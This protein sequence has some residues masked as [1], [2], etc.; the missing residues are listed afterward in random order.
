MLLGLVALA[1]AAAFVLGARRRRPAA[2]FAVG[3]TLV[4]LVP[5][6]SIVWRLDPVAVRPLYVAALGPVLLL[7]LA[8]AHLCAALRVAAPPRARL[9]AATA[10]LLLAATLPLVALARETRQR[11]Q[12]WTD[13]AA[14]WADAALKAPGSSRPWLNLGVA[15]LIDDRL[16][17]AEVALGAALAADPGEQRARCALASI[18][19]RRYGKTFDERSPNR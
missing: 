9:A 13:P 16:D 4:A 2:A 19:I 15:L 3:W 17:D 14:L 10:V 8:A 18:R 11:A 12:L 6:N 7:A 5:A 1:A